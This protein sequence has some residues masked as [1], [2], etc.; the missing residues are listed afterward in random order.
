MPNSIS[1]W[2][3]GALSESDGTPSSLRP[4]FWMW[5]A[6]LAII[7]IGTCVYTLYSHFHNPGSPFN[8]SGIATM[9]LSAFGMNRGSK[10][11]QKNLEPEATQN[12]QQVVDPNQQAIPKPTVGLVPPASISGL[13]PAPPPPK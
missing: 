2:I 11:I 10:L 7:F 6:I 3:A 5:E 8:P 4:V 1:S 12:Q 13:P 9:I